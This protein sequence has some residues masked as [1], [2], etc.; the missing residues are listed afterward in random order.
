MTE[1]TAEAEHQVVPGEVEGLESQ[2][3]EEKHQ[4]VFRP[5]EGDP[6]KEA[7]P[8]VPGLVAIRKY[9]WLEHRG[10]DRGVRKETVEMLQDALGAPVLV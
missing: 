1:A 5:R 6:L 7:G 2:G 8:D 3:V 9:P 4:L 10:V